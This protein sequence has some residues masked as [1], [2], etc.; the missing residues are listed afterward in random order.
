MGADITKISASLVSIELFR[1]GLLG[2]VV[3]KLFMDIWATI[4]KGSKNCQTFIHYARTEVLKD[5]PMMILVFRNMKPC[6][7][8]YR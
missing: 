6:K 5:L 2:A 8:A 4:L 3:L 7:S 1:L